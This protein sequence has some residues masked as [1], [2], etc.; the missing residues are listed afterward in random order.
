MKIY[1]GNPI[2]QSIHKVKRKQ[3]GNSI[4]VKV[5]D[6]SSTIT[7]RKPA[8]RD[9]VLQ[10]FPPPKNWRESPCYEDLS[11]LKTPNRIKI[12]DVFL[13]LYIFLSSQV[14]R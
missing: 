12:Q 3:N 9:R 5:A 8:G 13:I 6:Y 14:K 10:I 2:I 7:K 11:I 4:F 1:Q